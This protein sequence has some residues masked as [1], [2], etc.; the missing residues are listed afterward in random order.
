MKKIFF[1]FKFIRFYFNSGNAHGLHSP[2]VFNFYIN[3][4]SPKKTYYCF[5]KI[6]QLRE[7][8]KNNKKN[9]LFNDLGAG[10]QM[11]NSPSRK[12][13]S[14]AKNA[15][16]SPQVAQFLFKTI[17][18]FNPKNIFELGTS[19]GL[20]TSYLSMSK[21]ESTITT[22]EGCPNLI[23]IAKQNFT[24]LSLNNIHCVEG[25]IDETLKKNLELNTQIDLVFFD[26]N[27]RYESTL[28]YFETCLMK[29]TENSI[30][31]FDD[32]H[33]SS[34]M[35]LAW[36]EIKNHG[37]VTLTIDFFFLGFAFFRK[38]QPKQHFK[39]RL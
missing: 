8:L 30:F 7:E 34:E 35:E 36:Q 24:K 17:L 13:S 21:P 32:I 27:H 6:E 10:S 38:A 31:I 9:I 1:V 29:A 23:S 11:N 5:S 22:F 16:K 25:N 39:L 15:A 28:K 18:Y 3:V 4:V 2:F 26:A 12:I 19:L 20:T 14:I 37:N 33:W